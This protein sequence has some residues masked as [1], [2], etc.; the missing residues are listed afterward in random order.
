[1][2]RSFGPWTASA[3]VVGT[4]IGAGIFAM[5]SALAPYGW[6]AAGGWLIG[7]AG[8]LAIG[9]VIG[10]LTIRYPE[11]PSIVTICGDILGLMAGRI[12]AWSFWVGLIGSAAVLAIVSGE[13]TL[14]LLHVDAPGITGSLIGLGYL[15]AITALNLRGV[16]EAGRFQVAT[17]VLKLMPLALVI[18]IALTLA[19]TRPETYAPSPAVPFDAGQLVPVIGVS[20]F[21]LLGFETVGML[22]QRVRNPAR[23]V[24]LATVF[25]LLLVVLIYFGVSMGIV[26]ATP[27]EALRTDAAPVATFTQTFVGAWAAGAIALFATISAIGTLNSATLMLGDIPFGMVRDGQ[28]PEWMAPQGGNGIGRRPILLGVG[29]TVVLVLASNYSLGERLLDFLLRLTIATNI[30]FYVGI[31][32]AAL[33]VGIQ[34]VLSVVGVVFSAVLLYGT[35][36]EASLLGLALM[37]V[38]VAVHAAIGGRTAPRGSVPAE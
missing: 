11:E 5:P 13:Y 36:T 10:A 23:N 37:A 12:M 14:F 25:G 2:L 9:I 32:L 6:T 35:G 22:T 27:P 28:L 19:F 30:L 24:P 38:G 20:F 31:C 16:K 18:G 34:R 15:L 8:A 29:L 17:T 21:A 1:M 7:G 3:L 26:L 33:R 4:M